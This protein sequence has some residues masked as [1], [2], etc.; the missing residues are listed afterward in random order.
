MNTG[1]IQ[2]LG[3]M[4]RS[5]L[6][7]R[8][9]VN[10]IGR[11]S[12]GTAQEGQSYTGGYDA[13]TDDFVNSVVEITVDDV[14]LGI[15]PFYV[16]GLSTLLS[17]TLKDRTEL[18]CKALNRI[19]RWI[20]VDLL[21]RG[22][23]V[24][25]L[26]EGE[27]GA[28]VLIPYLQPLEFYMTTRGS[29]VAVTLSGVVVKDLLI[30]LNYSKESL[31]LVSNPDDSEDGVSNSEYLFRI[32]P[33]PIQLKNLEGIGAD[34]AK[35]EASVYSYRQ[36]LSRI[37]RL[38]AVDVGT[39][40][41]DRVDEIIDSV[42]Q[43][44]NAPSS[45]LGDSMAASGGMTFQ[46]GIPILPT[47]NGKGLPSIV[48]S[49]PSADISQLADLDHTLSKFF[50]AARF[51]KTY[52]DFN[53]HLD[54]S[55]VS[56][57]RGDIRYARMVLRAQSL[58]AETTNA[59]YHSSV[60]A[61]VPQ[62]EFKMVKLPTSEDNDVSDVVDSFMSMNNTWLDAI[63]G[64]ETKDVAEL[65]INSLEALLA[66]TSNLHSIQEWIG[67]ARDYVNRKF[68]EVPT[69]DETVPEDGGLGDD[70]MSEGAEDVDVPPT[71]EMVDEDLDAQLR[72]RA[73]AALSRVR[74]EYDAPASPEDIEL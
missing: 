73:S 62:V 30:Y 13:L 69:V 27:D 55:T 4:L 32:V 41:G 67:V 52:A 72:E 44:L 66:E 57:L 33:E 70:F 23:S 56:L 39:A 26:Q 31:E 3:M 51:P 2:S 53:S 29:V 19:A 74:E 22:V 20:G 43:V 21:K 37:I 36:Q 65:I 1:A 58:M 8:P 11:S 49:I 45:S 71:S 35:E 46:D 14:C 5:V 24:Y 25:Y 9:G 16:R 18:L 42:S 60:K 38:V 63:M 61:D 54:A 59:W 10:R 17:P 47:R 50:L 15:N 6:G 12:D 68:M 64:A 7:L 40:Q 28:P 34:L 48:E